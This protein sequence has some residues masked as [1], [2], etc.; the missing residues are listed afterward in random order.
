MQFLKHVSKD[1]EKNN[2][3]MISLLPVTYPSIL[4]IGFNFLNLFIQK[5]KSSSVSSQ[6]IPFNIRLYINIIPFSRTKSALTIQRTNFFL[7]ALIAQW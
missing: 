1:L 4:R 6:S 7:V 5:E 2:S 3:F